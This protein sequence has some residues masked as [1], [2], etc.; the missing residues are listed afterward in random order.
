[1]TVVSFKFLLQNQEYPKIVDLVDLRVYF[2]LKV[3][4]I[5]LKFGK[6]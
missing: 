6:K 5:A 4:L 3:L 2:W 1:M